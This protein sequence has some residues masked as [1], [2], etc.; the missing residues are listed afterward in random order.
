[1]VHQKTVLKKALVTQ[2]CFFA[3]N[4]PLG[5]TSNDVVIKVRSVLEKYVSLKYP[6]NRI[7]DKQ[8]RSKKTKVPLG[9]L[10]TLDPNASGVLPIA[11][12]PATK[13]I[14]LAKKRPP[15]F[16]IYT[17]KITLGKSTST[18]DQDENTSNY[19]VIREVD[20]SWL[21]KE[22]IEPH[23]KT[24]E[25]S[26]MQRPPT[27]AAKQIH[28]IRA[29]E[30]ERK[31]L[32][33][34]NLVQPVPVRIDNIEILDFKPGR[35]PEVDLRVTCGSGTYIRSLARDLGHQILHQNLGTNVLMEDGVWFYPQYVPGCGSVKELRRDFSDG[36]D[37]DQCIDI[38][39]FLEMF[40]SRNVESH[41]D[42][43]S[44]AKKNFQNIYSTM[45][46]IP[47]FSMNVC[48]EEEKKIIRS[49]R[50]KK[51]ICADNYGQMKHFQDDR[52]TS[53][54]KIDLVRAVVNGKFLGVGEK[55]QNKVRRYKKYSINN[56]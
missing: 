31:G 3:I 45:N 27:V 53:S 28:G 26:I 49:W 25:G 33:T 56:K 10:G 19:R 14:E 1:M 52:S 5:W 16:K 17:T 43:H 38:D 32:M 4:K 40:D 55:Y 47:E 29:H 6:T 21:T 11:C 9:H 54:G 18:D 23:L 8:K 51:P 34:S 46:Y 24:F 7:E 41:K 42:I 35:L 13:F 12:G 30:L 36:F 22:H 50:L 48:R 2:G 15:N 37:L 20:M 44:F 39:V